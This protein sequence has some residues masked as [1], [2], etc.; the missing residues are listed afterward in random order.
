MIVSAYA[1]ILLDSF[2]GDVFKG[3]DELM[4]TQI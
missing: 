4:I 2:T 3:L 1:T